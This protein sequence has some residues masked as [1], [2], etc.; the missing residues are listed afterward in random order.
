MRH[1]SG[2]LRYH[3]VCAIASCALLIAVS[4]GMPAWSMELRPHSERSAARWVA[5]GNEALMQGDIDSAKERY[6]QALALDARN[7]D[8]LFNLGLAWKEQEHWQ[9]ARSRFEEALMARPDSAATISNLG[10]LAWAMGDYQ[11]AASRFA[12]AAQVAAS[13]PREA[14]DYLYNLGTAR[15]ALREWSEARDAY[16]SAIELDPDHYGALYNLGTLYMG[17]HLRNSSN[18]ERHLRLAQRVA[19]DRPH[20][21]LNLAILYESM[22]RTS[23]AEQYYDTAVDLARN[24]QHELLNNTLWRRAQFHN[25]RQPPQKVAMRRDLEELLRRDPDFPGANGLLGRHYHALGDYERAIPL[26][27]RE[28]NERNFNP[29]QEDNVDVIFLLAR[30]FHDERPDRRKAMEYATRFYHLR[31]DSPR[32]RELRRRVRQMT[33]SDTTGEDS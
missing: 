18:A 11:E 28:V 32:E 26:L 4:A 14:A 5:E 30:I 22:G 12:A 13:N 19:P 17:Q 21:I 10:F 6:Q 25:R 15:E 3:A 24:R 23:D 27:E 9:Q 29:R 31:P 33:S 2:L 20:A 8:A 16:R 7:F 1:W